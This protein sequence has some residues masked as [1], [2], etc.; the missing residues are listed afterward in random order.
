MKVIITEQQKKFLTESITVYRGV[1]GNYHGTNENEGFLWVAENEEMAKDYATQDKDGKWNIEVHVIAEPNAFE[2]PYRESTYVTS[3]NVANILRQVQHRQIK[4]KKIKSL[5]EALE[6]SKMI[7]H[8]QSLAGDKVEPFHT[9]LNKHV[10]SR[11]IADVLKR[12]GY[13]AVLLKHGENK[14]YGIIK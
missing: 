4:S 9:K 2:F 8:Y 14:T 10:A 3:E 12:L 6:I 11:A 1:G 7:A 13:D 5:D